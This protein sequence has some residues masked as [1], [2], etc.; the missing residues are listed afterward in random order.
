MYSYILHNPPTSANTSH[1]HT[2]T[3]NKNRV[4]RPDQLHG[5]HSLHD[6]EVIAYRHEHLLARTWHAEEKKK[7]SDHGFRRVLSSTT[8][9]QFLCH[10]QE[11]Y[12]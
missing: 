9:G 7:T 5:S 12:K 11:P 6:G 2:C 8:V 3:S 10:L 4:D 1:I